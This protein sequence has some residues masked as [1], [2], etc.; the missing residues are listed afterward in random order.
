MKFLALHLQCVSPTPKHT[1]SHFK[2]TLCNVNRENSRAKAFHCEFKKG[3]SAWGLHQFIDR[4][5][6]LRQENGFIDY[7]SQDMLSEFD[8]YLHPSGRRS[9]DN[10]QDGGGSPCIVIEV[11]LRIVHPNADGNYDLGLPSVPKGGIIHDGSSNNQN[12]MMRGSVGAG[13]SSMLGGSPGHS[14]SMPHSQNNQNQNQLS[15]QS[16]M[17][18]PDAVDI[19]LL[20]PSEG[21]TCDMSL[22]CAR[23]THA[24]FESDLPP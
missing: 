21:N 2:L 10:L 11:L 14:A 1:Y 6:M 22:T 12:S 17:P 19:A 7:G 18:A 24:T 3:G 20:A 16:R 8:Q 23:G 13:N 5:R 4:E 15:L 9:G